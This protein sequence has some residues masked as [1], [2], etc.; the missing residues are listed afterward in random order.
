M[1]WMCVSH[2]PYIG[3]S[4][5]GRVDMEMYTKSDCF[6]LRMLRLCF[7]TINK[8]IKTTIKQLRNEFDF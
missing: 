3:T 7:Y 6:H 4:D 8:Q 2:I 5:N 1:V